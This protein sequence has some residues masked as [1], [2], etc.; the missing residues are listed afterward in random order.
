[1]GNGFQESAAANLPRL[2]GL[3]VRSRAGTE[4]Y[5]VEGKADLNGALCKIGWDGQGLTRTSVTLQMINSYWA[6][7]GRNSQ[8]HFTV[9]PDGR[10][11]AFQSQT[12]LGANIGMI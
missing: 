8:N 9:S 5:F 10:F 1:V 11:E 2:G 3:V 4:I 7:P 12:V 6:D